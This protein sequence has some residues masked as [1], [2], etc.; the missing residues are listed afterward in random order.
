MQT[1][2]WR[3]R[4]LARYQFPSI[5]SM[6]SMTSSL[7]RDF[8]GALAAL[9]MVVGVRAERSAA[10]N[11]ADAMAEYMRMAAATNP[12]PTLTTFASRSTHR[13]MP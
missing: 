6:A 4:L 5:R 2:L 7:T 12:K 1:A 3:A 9:D 11:S 8:D 10:K 13:M